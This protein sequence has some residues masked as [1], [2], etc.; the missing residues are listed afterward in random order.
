MKL[1]GLLFSALF[2]IAIIAVVNRVGFLKK[3]TMPAPAAS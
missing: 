1:K 3:V 2:V